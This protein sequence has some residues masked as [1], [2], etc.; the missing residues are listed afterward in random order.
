MRSSRRITNT[1]GMNWWRISINISLI[2]KKDKKLKTNKNG[3]YFGSCSLS[4]NPN[5][6]RTASNQN[7]RVCWWLAMNHLILRIR[8][9]DIPL[10]NIEYI[11]KN[12]RM[13]EWRARWI[14]WGEPWWSLQETNIVGFVVG[15]QFQALQ[16]ENYQESTLE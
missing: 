10:K 13:Y 15:L 8:K 9:Y 12:P 3:Y 6:K 4:H 1:Y 7:Q 14:R 5:L 16:Q 11:Q 2:K